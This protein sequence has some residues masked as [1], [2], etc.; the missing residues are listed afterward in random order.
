MYTIYVSLIKNCKKH[1]I[2]SI[3]S[4]QCF[5]EGYYRFSMS[6]FAGKL[7]SPFDILQCVYTVLNNASPYT[8]LLRRSIQAPR[9]KRFFKRVNIGF[10]SA[11][12]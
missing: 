1:K 7:E 12:K 4:I 5:L 9:V 10:L 6:L 2:M 8:A 3:Q 11:N